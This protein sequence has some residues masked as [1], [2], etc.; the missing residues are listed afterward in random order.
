MS[1]LWC[2]SQIKAQDLQNSEGKEQNPIHRDFLQ[3]STLSGCTDFKTYGLIGWD[4]SW[5]NQDKLPK[6][7]A[8]ELF[9]TLFHGK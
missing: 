7:T 8:K 5:Q 1:I 3:G 6:L 9:R 2:L 4:S